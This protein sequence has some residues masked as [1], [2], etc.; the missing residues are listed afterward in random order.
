MVGFIDYTNH[1][2]EYLVYGQSRNMD[3]PQAWTTLMC[4]ILLQ[5]KKETSWDRWQIM[6]N[7]VYLA[8]DLESTSFLLVNTCCNHLHYTS[9]LAVYF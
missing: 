5:P 8:R 9:T 3:V 7:S 6:S 4:Q 2:Y 1:F